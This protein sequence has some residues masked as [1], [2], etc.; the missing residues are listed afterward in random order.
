MVEEYYRLLKPEAGHK[1]DIAFDTC[2]IDFADTRTVIIH[3]L[4]CI[5][6]TANTLFLG[7]A[8]KLGIA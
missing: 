8:R 7:I 4:E 6:K 2:S 3:L 1:F 5:F